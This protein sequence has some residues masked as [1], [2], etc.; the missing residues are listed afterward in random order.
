MLKPSFLLKQTKSIGGYDFSILGI[1]NQNIWI[2]GQ[3][4]SSFNNY[5]F[6]NFQ[7]T[8]MSALVGFQILENLSLGYSYGIPSNEISNGI[9]MP[10]HEIFLRLDIFSK[11]EAFLFSPRFF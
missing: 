6:T 3:I 2:G 9:S 8:G 1:I 10:T 11:G 4:R 5:G 7:G